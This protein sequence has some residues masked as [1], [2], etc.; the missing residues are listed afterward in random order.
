MKRVKAIAAVAR[1][2]LVLLG[3]A[4]MVWGG[5]CSCSTGHEIDPPANQGKIIINDESYDMALEGEKFSITA[6]DG[7][8]DNIS[9]ADDG[10]ITAKESFF[11]KV[12]VENG[13][14]KVTLTTSATSVISECITDTVTYYFVNSAGTKLTKTYTP[15]KFP[16]GQPYIG[17]TKNIT[18]DT[19]FEVAVCDG[20]LDLE[21]VYG[22]TAITVSKIVIEKESYSERA[23][24]YLIAVGDSTLALG[25]KTIATSSTYCSWGASISN[26]HVS[27]PS[28]I[29]GFINCGQ[30]GGD[31]V[32]I[33]TDAR[34]EKI[35]LNCRPGDYVSVNIGINNNKDY[36]IGGQKVDKSGSLAAMGPILE[37]YL[38][39]AVKERGGIPF[40]T[41]ITAQGP[42]KP[43]E[44]AENNS[45]VYNNS[46][47]KITTG[48]ANTYL[49]YFD[50]KYDLFPSSSYNYYAG[51]KY[52]V[53]SGSIP[54]NT[55]IN[56]RHTNPYNIALIDIANYYKCDIVDLGVYG[57]KYLNEH[58]SKSSDFATVRDE[59]YADKHHYRQKCGDI[60]AKYML[61]CVTE[62]HE[63]TYKYPYDDY[64]PNFRYTG[65]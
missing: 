26:G 10:I 46:A 64:E 19:P 28:S 16:N 47:Q 56:S 54:A 61:E 65:K 60:L 9:I 63:G 27:L 33:Y 40:I 57:E 42:D 6:L 14:Y 43:T 5:E 62:M 21:F 24:P 1:R 32:T 7:T 51:V 23:K 31:A 15:S 18:S 50:A 4:A 36:S 35:L 59:Y 48:Y 20:V 12:P 53:N 2:A 58:L 38:I 49:S 29:G 44:T 3:M 8:V 13:N 37:K 34:I 45:G 52:T 22:S 41:T 30:S 55:W 39:D 11:I 17:I 25:D